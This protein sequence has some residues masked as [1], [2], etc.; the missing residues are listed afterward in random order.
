MTNP[1]Y[2]H[3]TYPAPNAPGSSAAL[4]AEFDKVEQGFEKLPTLSGQGGKLVA[5]KADA[6][7]LEAMSSAS[8]QAA[9]ASLFPPFAGNN[10][11]VMRVNA[12]ATDVEYFDVSGTGNVTTDGAQ[13]LTN[14]TIDFNANTLT[15]FPTTDLAQLHAVA[16]SF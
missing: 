13:T 14:K 1:Y 5:V 16:L 10:G 3:T 2:D 8:S 4:R 7:G 15:N 11:R 9:R 6:S 12:T